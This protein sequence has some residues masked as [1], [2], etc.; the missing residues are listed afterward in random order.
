MESDKLWELVQKW[1]ESEE[2]FQLN[3]DS[4]DTL[5]TLHLSESDFYNIASETLNKTTTG[6]GLW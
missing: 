5:S 1:K 3:G 6:E 2:S 4:L